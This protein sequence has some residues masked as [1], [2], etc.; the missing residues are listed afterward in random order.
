[1]FFDGGVLIFLLDFTILAVSEI[2]E[3]CCV[4]HDL[5]IN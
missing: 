1:M 4:D 5:L 2:N 3:L